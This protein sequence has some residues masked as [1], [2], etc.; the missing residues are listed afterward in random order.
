MECCERSRTWGGAPALAALENLSLLSL[1][2][3]KVARITELTG[4]ESPSCRLG[5]PLNSQV[6][7]HIPTTGTE[8]PGLE[9][10]AHAVSQVRVTSPAAAGTIELE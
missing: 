6:L 9:E 2:L 4:R 1:T 3:R 8:R 7:Q 10:D 5:C